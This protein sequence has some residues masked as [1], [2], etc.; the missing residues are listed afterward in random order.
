MQAGRT[1]ILL[2]EAQGV[3]QAAME[4]A[5]EIGQPMN[6]AVVDNGRDLKAF[7]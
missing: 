6:V 5:E 7:S 2:D 1:S 3:I 4:K